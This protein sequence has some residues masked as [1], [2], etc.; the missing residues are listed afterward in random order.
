MFCNGL[1][2][3]KME[4]LSAKQALLDLMHVNVHLP[5]IAN[6]YPGLTLN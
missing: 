4:K 2:K 3:I 5:K 1:F 6:D